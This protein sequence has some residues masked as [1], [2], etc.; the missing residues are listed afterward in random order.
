M[1]SE[2]GGWRFSEDSRTRLVVGLLSMDAYQL[3]SIVTCLT[4]MTTL[5]IVSVAVL[6]HVKNGMVIV[7]DAILWAALVLLLVALAWFGFQEL[8]QREL[9]APNHAPDQNHRGFFAREDFYAGG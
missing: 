7:R 1:L 4:S 5:I 9:L 2:G 3:I 8:S 6:P